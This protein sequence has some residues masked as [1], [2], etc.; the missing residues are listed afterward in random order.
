MLDLLLWSYI[1]HHASLT[2]IDIPC[3]ALQHYERLS[4]LQPTT[5]LLD[6]ELTLL[7]Y[8]AKSFDSSTQTVP[9]SR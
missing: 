4:E 5:V 1:C 2:T 6:K 7:L 3:L 9:E 8:L